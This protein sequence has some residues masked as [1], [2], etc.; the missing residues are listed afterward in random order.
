[1]TILAGVV[2]VLALIALV[3][4]VNMAPQNLSAAGFDISHS[5]SVA[6]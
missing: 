3:A 4:V 1:M 5:L 6:G 2:A